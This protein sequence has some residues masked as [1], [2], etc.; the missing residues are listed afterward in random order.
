MTATAAEY[1]VLPA[2]R[3]W[4]VRCASGEES[5]GFADKGDAVGRAFALARRSREWRVVVL[6]RDG[7]V[8][9]ELYGLTEAIRMSPPSSLF[10]S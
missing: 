2:A 4:V 3:G 6:A 7:K 1:V 8:E 10:S 5:E 9:T